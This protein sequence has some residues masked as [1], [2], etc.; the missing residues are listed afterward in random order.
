MNGR[1]AEWRYVSAIAEITR[2]GHI[3][4]TKDISQALGVTS[5]S[6]SDMLKKMSRDGLIEYRPYRG[7]RLTSSGRETAKMIEQRLRVL[8]EFFTFIGMSREG[9]SLEAR[10][11]AMKIGEESYGKLSGLVKK[12]KSRVEQRDMAELIGDFSTGPEPGDLYGCD[13]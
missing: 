4:R 1:E 2:G 7:A 5:P 3:A 8:E 11:M 13:M 9:A 10:S 12:L 6:V